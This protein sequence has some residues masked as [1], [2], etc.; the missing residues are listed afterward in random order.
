MTIKILLHKSNLLAKSDSDDR[1]FSGR[2]KWAAAPDSWEQR[3]KDALR[4]FELDSMPRSLTELDALYAKLK[5]QHPREIRIELDTHYATLRAAL[6]HPG[7]AN[8]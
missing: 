4:F 3:I 8:G 5:V 7:S 1:K 6:S 2:S